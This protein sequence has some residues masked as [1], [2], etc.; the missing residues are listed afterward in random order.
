M[1]EDAFTTR[2]KPEWYQ[3]LQLKFSRR[4]EGGWRG[5]GGAGEEDEVSLSD[6]T[7]MAGNAAGP[8]PP[9]TLG[10]LASPRQTQPVVR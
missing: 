9:E 8:A 1:A 3:S 5:K 2:G 6:L 10:F 4:K 7:L